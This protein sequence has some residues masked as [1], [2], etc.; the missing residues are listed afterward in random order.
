M[1]TGFALLMGLHGLIHLLGPAKAFGWA[2]VSQLRQP[3]SPLG[4]VLWLV[5]ALV[6]LGA[7]LA[8]VAGAGW[9]WWFAGAGVSLSQI[10][11]VLH[12]HDARFGTLANLVVAVP[13]VLLATDAR[14]GSFRSRFARD[15]AALLARS[16]GATAK[17][18]TEADLAPLPPLMQTYLRRVGAVGRP[19]VRNL[20]VVFD[21]QMRSAADAPWMPSTASQVEGFAPAAPAR[22]FH[23]RASRSGVPFDVL[24]EY[25]EGAAT[26]QVRIVGVFPVV[27]KSGPALTH[28]ETVTLM[29]DVLVLAPAAV[30]DLPF[31]FEAAAPDA[32]GNPA[33]PRT[34]RATFRNAGFVVAATLTF[35]PAGDL[36]GFVSA[37]RAHD[38]EGGAALWS[39]P[40]SAYAVVDGI[41]LGTRGDANWIDA[42]GEWTYG[43]FVVR[44]IAYNLTSTAEQERL[45]S[46]F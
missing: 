23:M 21:A 37:D 43:R 7:A 22:L 33:R 15:G 12:W 28:D 27:D 18:V 6:L 42:T 10:L 38:R 16:A 4:G 34:L 29:N 13:L 31:T 5:A 2:T 35:D 14:A 46:S 41:R 3:I 20:R 36:V 30:L 39:T 40:I 26:F 9:W 44:S 45:P 8:F 1:R 17:T 19:A 24:H 25:V 11:I 32:P